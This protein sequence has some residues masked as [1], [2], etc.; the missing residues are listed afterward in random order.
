MKISLA[1]FFQKYKDISLDQ[2]QK[3]IIYDKF[4]AVAKSDFSYQENPSHE[5][6]SRP[7]RSDYLHIYL[8]KNI[9]W[10]RL[11]IVMIV[12]VLVMF[13]GP[14]KN[15][16]INDWNITQDTVYAESIWHI[17]KVDGKYSVLVNNAEY[18]TDKIYD[19]STIILQSW[20]NIDFIVNEK[21][22]GNIKWPAK[23]NFKKIN[24]EYALN[25]LEWDQLE[26]HSVSSTS[27]Q[28]NSSTGSITNK[29]DI[30]SRTRIDNTIDPT[31]TITENKN[32]TQDKDKLIVKDTTATDLWSNNTEIKDKNKLS[33]D[34]IKVTISTPKFIAKADKDINIK[35]STHGKNQ[36]LQNQ[37]WLLEIKSKKD[38]K[39]IIMESNQVAV[40]DE[41]VS[42][43]SNLANISKDISIISPESITSIISSQENNPI[44]IKELIASD[45]TSTGK[46]ITSKITTKQ[47]DQDNLIKLES[48]GKT[49]IISWG[50]Q[51]EMLA[52]TSRIQ[53]ANI[54]QSSSWKITS[55]IIDN[56]TSLSLDNTTSADI[57]KVNIST[58]KQETDISQLYENKTILSQDQ[59]TVIKKLISHYLPDGDIYNQEDDIMVACKLFG[60]A[61]PSTDDVSILKSYLKKIIYIVNRDYYTDND[62][63]MPTIR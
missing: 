22:V 41:E 34:D 53:E 7:S 35:I 28:D 55:G 6:P 14:I 61:C 1:E 25:L 52:M 40:V 51:V 17:V 12:V 43:F 38:D 44:D 60:L 23:L 10:Y 36:V 19:W 63:T 33:K 37:N 4:M 13:Y 11:A 20:S 49:T 21:I 62:L 9:F 39:S 30:D 59:L 57:Q 5:H 42:L 29:S 50:E 31:P 48:S 54:D 58:P 8:K 24:N 18:N 2:K 27:D 16:L 56:N 3:D 15:Y 46:N 32:N 45:N 26:I 47:P